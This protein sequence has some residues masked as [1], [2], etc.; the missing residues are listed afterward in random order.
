MS[1]EP[2]SD[3]DG[4]VSSSPSSVGSTKYD[5]DGDQKAD[6]SIFRPG[7]GEWWYLQSSDGLNRAFQFGAGSDVL[8]PADYTG[9]G[10]T[11][12]AFFRPGTGE[13]FVLRSEDFSFYS[14]P[15]GTSGDI[16]VVGDYDGDGVADPA[17]FRPSNNTWFNLQSTS[18]FEAVAFGI[19][20]DVPVASSLLPN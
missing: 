20:N 19:A 12:V 4:V 11:D 2:G 9:D 3:R 7:P 1:V 10:K 14:F 15:F 17:V 6:V 16:P 8:V 5:L 18:G 13:W